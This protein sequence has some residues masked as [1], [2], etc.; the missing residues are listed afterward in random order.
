MGTRNVAAAHMDGGDNHLIHIQFMHQ[1]THGCDV[2][3][4]I[5]GAHLVEVNLMDG[6]AVDM[7]LCLRDFTVDCHDIQ[8]HQGRDGKP[9][10]NAANVCHAAMMMRSLHPLVFFFSLERHRHVGSAD[11]A[12]D[13][14][15]RRHRNTGDAKLIQSPEKTGRIGQ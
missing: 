15:L 10:D 4:G 7:A 1:Q 13:T 5:H 3:N 8:L 11:S 14:F 9:V 6:N 12:F 2:G